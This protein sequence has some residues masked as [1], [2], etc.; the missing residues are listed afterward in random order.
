MDGWILILFFLA[1]M[2]MVHWCQRMLKQIDRI[3]FM[4]EKIV[5]DAGERKK[6]ER[7]SSPK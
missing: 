3:T 6:V 7:S 4:L 2:G 5:E 1:T